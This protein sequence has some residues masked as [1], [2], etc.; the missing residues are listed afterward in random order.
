VNYRS[1]YILIAII[2]LNIRMASTFYEVLGVSKFASTDDIKKAYK[3]L[4]KKYHPDK[5]PG[6]KFH[7]EHFK[8]INEAYQTL[9]NQQARS[10][11]DLKINYAESS[12]PYTT[13]TQ[14]NRPRNTNPNP[15]KQYAQKAYKKPQSNR[16]TQSQK[17]LNRYYIYIAI[18]AVLFIVA[19]TWFYNFMNDYAAKEYF[20]EGLQEEQK[21]NEVKAMGY[22]FSSLEKNFN[23]PIVNEKI[24]DIYSK[25][26]HNNSIE[27][28]YFDLE[29]QKRNIDASLDKE[30]TQLLNNIRDIDSLSAMYFNRSF[31]NYEL[32]SDKRRVG[33]KLLRTDLKIGNF[34]K[35][36]YDSKRLKMMP[37]AAKDDS[38]I[39]YQAEIHFLMKNY[40]E[41]RK[42][43]TSFYAFH[44]TSA[45][46]LIKIALCNYNEHNEDFAIN[47][48]DKAILKFP[49]KGEAYYF[50]GE[51]ARRN[52]DSIAACNLFEIADQLN[53]LAAKTAIYKYCQ[54]EL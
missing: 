49:T 35:G 16:S 39:Y 44:P 12:Q 23:N 22:Y 43:Y 2:E 36:L 48:L 45:D 20:T 53:I 37:D 15:E 3:N 13:N 9:S 5:H 32:D 24:G 19:S 46:A 40:E 25:L 6:S 34:S 29:L 21:G 50:K 7:E 27:L 38:L 54:T 1:F 41:A 18:G 42:S 51:I 17:K 14:A 52:Q 33:L 8:K 28:F 11:Y 31:E 26:A 30:S 47:Q 10:R 4:A